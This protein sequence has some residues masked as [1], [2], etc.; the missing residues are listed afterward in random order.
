M[1]IRTSPQQNGNEAAGV[2]SAEV[3]LR[4]LTPLIHSAV[5]LSLKA[6]SDAAGFAPPK[7]YRY[8]VSFVRV[9]LVERLDENG[10]YKLGPLAAELGFATLR[11]LDADRL[12]REAIASLSNELGATTVMV[13]WTGSGPLIIAIEHA[14]FAGPAFIS[15]RVGSTLQITRSAS[16]LVFLAFMGAAKRDAILPAAAQAEKNSIADVLQSLEQVRARGY[17]VVSNQMAVGLTGLAV[18]VFEL[19]G[20]VR[21]ALAAIWLTESEHVT[22]EKLAAAFTHAAA[23]LSRKFGADRSSES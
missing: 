20:R 7:A 4:L 19:G 21:F 16:G 23:Q 14:E 10:Y 22:E 8:L 18:P 3:G 15:M 11:Q 5:P 13:L 2:Q 17:A 6:I 12:G 1:K 9:G